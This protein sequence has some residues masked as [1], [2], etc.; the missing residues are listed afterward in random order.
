M[1]TATKDP[2]SGRMIAEGRDEQ[3]PCEKGTTGCCI[4]HSAESGEE[5]TCETW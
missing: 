4:V 1:E 3:D 5:G 2:Y